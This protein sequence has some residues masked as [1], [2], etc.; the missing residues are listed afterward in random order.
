LQVFYSPEYVRAAHVFDTTRK[1]QWIA[2]S[3]KRSPIED[4]EL[5]SPESLTAEVVAHIHDPQYVAAVSTGIPPHLAESSDIPWDPNL[6][7]AVL[8]SNGGVVQAALTAMSEGTAGSLSSGLHHARYGRGKG[9]CT[10]NGLALAANAAL[11]ERASSV[12]ILDLDAHCGGGTHLLTKKDH[13]IWQLDISVSTYDHYTNIPNHILKIVDKYTDYLP[14]IR[15]SLADF[16]HMNRHYDLCLYNAGMDPSEDSDIEEDPDGAGLNGITA[17]ILADREQLVFDW[18]RSHHIPVA[19]VL[20][21][22]YT[23]GRLKKE[24]LV[25]LHRLTIEAALKQN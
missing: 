9:F 19:F 3:L 17:Q 21:G 2:E 12:L 6:W 18:C 15:S 22:G 11:N 1:A 25:Q 10:F 8:A 16:S 23:G 7:P 13:R 14:I 4:V 5:R 20:A 24:Q